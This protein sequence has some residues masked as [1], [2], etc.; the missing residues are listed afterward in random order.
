MKKQYLTLA[1]TLALVFVANIALT[2]GPPDPPGDPG[3][4]GPPVGGGASLDGG[5]GFLIGLAAAWGSQKVY[6]LWK[7]KEDKDQQPE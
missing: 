6:R 7:K 1:I 5:I 4:G 3:S 2:Q